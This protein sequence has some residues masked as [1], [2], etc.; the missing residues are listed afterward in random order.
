V[1]PAEYLRL[2]TAPFEEHE[3]TLYF[4]WLDYVTIDREALRLHC[5]AVQNG[6]FRTLAQ[7]GRFKAQGVTAGVADISIDVPSG[8][9]HGLRIEMKRVGCKPSGEQLIHM[10]LRR[11]M[12]Y[13]AICCQGFDEARRATINYLKQGWLVTDRWAN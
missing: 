3:Q 12:G 4:R 13:Q 1:T 11:R 5:Y 9:F 8:A 6:G 10:E 7:A 2:L